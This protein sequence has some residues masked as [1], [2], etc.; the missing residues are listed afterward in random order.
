MPVGWGTMIPRHKCRAVGC[1]AHVTTDCCGASLPSP[2]T[3]W[4]HGA[5]VYCGDGYGCQRGRRR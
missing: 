5:G 1:C 4:V 3:A 2:R